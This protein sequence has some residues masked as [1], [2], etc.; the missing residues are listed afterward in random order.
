MS[1]IRLRGM[2]GMLPALNDHYLPDHNAADA[3]NIELWSPT[4]KPAKGPLAVLQGAISPTPLALFQ[5]IDDVWFQWDEVADVARSPV[6]NEAFGRVYYTKSDGPWVTDSTIYTTGGEPYPGAEY[7]P[8]VPVPTSAPTGTPGG[9]GS[10]TETRYYIYCAVNEYGEIGPPSPVSTAVTM[11]S[12]ANC[13][14]AFSTVADGAYNP[15]DKY[16]IY[17]SNLIGSGFQFVDEATSS[18]YVDTV[19]AL[20][21]LLPSTDW[22]PPP[23][24]VQ[25]LVSLPNG[26]QAAFRGN[27]LCMSEPN[28]PHAW[29]V[30]YRKAVDYDIVALGAIDNGCAIL[31]EGQPYIMVGVNPPSMAP[32]RLEVPYACVSKSGVVQFG[33]TVVY[34]SPLGLVSVDGSGARLLTK[35]VFTLEQWTAL[36]PST[37]KAFQYRNLYI[38]FYMDGSGDDRGFMFD[39]VNPSNGVS[40]FYGLS[41]SAAYEDPG[42]GSVFIST[43]GNI[44]QWAAGSNQSFSWKSKAYELPAPAPMR[45]VQVMAEQYPVTANVYR[46]G[47]L[48]ARVELGSSE[49]RR[50]PNG[51]RGRVYQIELISNYEIREVALASSMEEIRRA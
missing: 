22:D 18:P 19:V 20:G 40:Y 10:I 51:A 4:L 23:T 29:P 38:G 39:P 3:Y 7:R 33:D 28:L 41:M 30:P 46:D 1:M 14:V 50:I 5:Y 35:D 9:S 2:L 25:G 36:R 47:V 11:S 32:I 21:E 16:Y 13:S 42:T 24:D 45:C 31:T 49:P 15:V 12:H 6:S 48:Q 8:G 44:A 34:P 27:E 17:R 26:I 43:E 37:L